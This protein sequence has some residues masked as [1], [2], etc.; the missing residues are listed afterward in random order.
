MVEEAVRRRALW[1]G[2]ALRDEVCFRL[3][4]EEYN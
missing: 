2:G 1:R 4:K 3:L